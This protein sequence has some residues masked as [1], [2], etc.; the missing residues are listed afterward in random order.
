MEKG[1][2]DLRFS[3]QMELTGRLNYVKCLLCIAMEGLILIKAFWAWRR[4]FPR[5][6][7]VT[8]HFDDIAILGI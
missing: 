1:C 8:A 7:L 5:F 2:L 6:L 4:T 3:L